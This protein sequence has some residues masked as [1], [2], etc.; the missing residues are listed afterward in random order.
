MLETNH[1]LPLYLVWF[2]LVFN[3]LKFLKL[4]LLTSVHLYLN[5]FQSTVLHSKYACPSSSSSR[6]SSG[7]STGSILVITYE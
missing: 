7:L 5:H 4:N 2:G 3:S 1:V 6:S